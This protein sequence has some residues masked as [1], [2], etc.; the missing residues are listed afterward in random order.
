MSAAGGEPAEQGVRSRQDFEHQRDGDEHACADDHRHVQGRRLHQA[1][2]PSQAAVAV[3]HEGPSR[4]EQ[5]I[6][7]REQKKAARG[8]SVPCSLFPV[9]YSSIS[10]LHCAA[11]QA[12]W[13]HRTHPI[14]RIARVQGVDIMSWT[15]IRLAPLALAVAVVLGGSLQAAGPRDSLKKGT[16]E[17]QSIGAL[18]FGPEGVLFIADPAPRPSSPWTRRTTAPLPAQI[19]PKSRRSMR[20]SPRCSASRQANSRS[21]TSPSIRSRAIRTCR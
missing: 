19:V 20:R 2:L 12:S 15:R 14:H 16:P 9:P 10:N 5:G 21:T 13:E 17:L 8:F 3:A 6:G 11:E 1:E 4:R 7:N 18:T